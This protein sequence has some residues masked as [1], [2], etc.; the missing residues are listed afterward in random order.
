MTDNMTIWNAGR[1]V[2]ST[3]LKP[4]QAG[5]LKG[6]SDINPVWRMEV[7]TSLFGP[8]GFGWRTSL[9]SRWTETFEFTNPDGSTIQ[10]KGAFV[11]LNLFIKVNG[12]WSE[13]IEGVGGSKLYGKGQG[14][15]LND[16]A[17]KMAET[18]AISVACKKLGIA[19]DV[20]YASGA[21]Y[22][23]KYEVANATQNAVATAPQNTVATAP[24]KLELTAEAMEKIAD[25]LFKASTEMTKYK[26]LENGANEKYIISP[27]QW[28]MIKAIIANKK[29]QA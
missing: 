12:E 10:E 28:I 18:D 4:I 15:E 24:Q 22:E 13:A 8:C 17:W 7:L 29:K 1:A 3:A 6:K 27:E 19:A 21:R 14:N 11:K 9:V 26:R 23:T 2:P 5:K 20:Y 16:E 25:A